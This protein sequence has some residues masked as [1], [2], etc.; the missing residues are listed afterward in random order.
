M[1]LIPYLDFCELF[2]A[3]QIEISVETYDKFAQYADFLAEKNA[4]MNLMAIT[5]PAEVAEKHFLD[6]A[7]PLKLVDFPE[8]SSLVDVGAGA[9][10]PSLPMAIL[11]PDLRVT[12][13]DSLQKRVKFL[14]EAAEML[15]LPAVCL[16]QRA[17]DCGQTELR[18]SF[19]IAVAR[20]VSRLSVLSEYCLPLVRVG[21]MFAALKG[22]DCG[23]EIESAKPAIKT[24]GGRI[25]RVCEYALPNGDRRTLVIVRKIAATPRAYPRP[26]GKIKSKPL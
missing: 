1:T 19:D 14:K 13:V 8:G 10:F 16:H 9:G 20:A 23:E 7:L 5:D 2:R 6:S 17:E 12:M 26:Q 15:G 11:R 24:L 22:A 18:E 25:E 3:A 21:G 4:V